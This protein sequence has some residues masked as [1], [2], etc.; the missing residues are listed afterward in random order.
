M[1]NVYN[2]FYISTRIQNTGKASF[3][4]GHKSPLQLGKL[5]TVILVCPADYICIHKLVKYA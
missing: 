1:L 5:D 4:L 3:P 2:F